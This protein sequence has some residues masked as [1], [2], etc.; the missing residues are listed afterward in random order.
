MT[1]I[2]GIYSIPHPSATDAPILS[3]PALASHVIAPLKGRI[4][5]PKS[6][7]PPSPIVPVYS[8]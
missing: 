3:H 4:Q 5:H 2:S 7:F 8:R 1:F 6:P